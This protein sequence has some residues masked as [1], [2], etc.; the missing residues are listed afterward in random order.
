MRNKPLIRLSALFTS[1]AWLVCLGLFSSFIGSCNTSA[2]KSQVGQTR[3]AADLYKN[4]CTTC[5]G[6]HMERFSSIDREALFAMPQAKMEETIREGVVAA[7]MPAFADVLTGEETSALAQYILT[8]IKA[9]AANYEFRPGFGPLIK[10]DELSFH[11]DTV[12]SGLSIPWGMA[13]LPNGDLLVTERSGELFRFRA[14]KLVAVI[15]DVP[16]VYAKGQGGLLDIKMHPNYQENGWIYLAYSAPANNN[17][18]GGHTAIVRARLQEDR[19]FNV[20]RIFKAHPDTPSGVHFGCRMAF[21]KNGYLFFSIGERGRMENAQDLTNHSGKIHRLYDDGSI[22]LDN[23]FVNTDDAQQ[24]IWSYGHRNPQGLAFH[25]VTGELW[26]TEHGPKGGDELNIIKRGANYG[27]P[28]ITYGINYNGTIITPDTAR[29]GLE[30]PISYWTPSIAPCGLAFAD[31][32]R[33]PKWANNLFSGSL[34]F[35]YVV[36]TQLKGD[37]VEKD[38]IMIREAGRVRVI[39]T[40]PDGYLY[41]GVENPGVVFRLIPVEE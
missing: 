27:W 11:I 18:E 28:V 26:E 29:A 41:I 22:P 17:A 13:W 32:T 38:E 25:P 12:A 31:A 8:D 20:E 3:Q 37:H 39:E 10:T 34:S 2:S 6:M 9:S 14:G 33:Y 19:L 24:S 1:F 4:Y 23:P 30:Q 16:A 36:R 40:G 35:R 21:D 7:G 5:H 15:E